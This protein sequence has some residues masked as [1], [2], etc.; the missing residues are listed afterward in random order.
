VGYWSLLVCLAALVWL[1]LGLPGPVQAKCAPAYEADV[2]YGLSAVPADV[3]L[4][5]A[6][7]PRASDFDSNESD[8][9][10]GCA[11]A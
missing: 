4:A 3:Q 1:L 11:G 2:L 9:T 7:L 6:D 10:S 5:G 8:A